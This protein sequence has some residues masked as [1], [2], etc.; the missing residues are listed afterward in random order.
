MAIFDG[1]ISA[2]AA[3]S[4]R[5]HD[6]EE[7]TNAQ[8]EALENQ[9]ACLTNIFNQKQS[10]PQ[11]TLKYPCNICGKANETERGLRNHVRTHQTI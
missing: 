4:A 5:Q 7:K 6:Y 3:F 11:P 8:F 1:T 10:I 2:F 9:L